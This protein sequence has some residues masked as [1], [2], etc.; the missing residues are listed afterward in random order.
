MKILLAKQP[1]TDLEKYLEVLR[2]RNVDFEEIEQPIKGDVLTSNSAKALWCETFYKEFRERVD[3]VQFFLPLKDWPESRNLLGRMFNRSFSGYLTSCTRM[4]SGYHKTAEHELLHKADNWVRIY[5]GISIERILGISDW[6]DVVVHGDVPGDEFTEYNYDRAWEIIRPYV[7]E[8]LVKRKNLALLGY[9]QQLLILLRT[10]LANLEAK[11]YTVK[12]MIHPFEDYQVTQEYG[13]PNA[14]WYPLT[15]HHIGS[16]YATPIGTPIPALTDGEIVQAGHSK[17]LGYYCY[18]QH[19]KN[20]K[21]YQARFMHLQALPQRKTYKAGE[22]IGYTGDTGF[23]TGPCVHVDV[24]PGE[25]RIDLINGSNWQQM[26]VN[27]EKHF[28]G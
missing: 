7:D 22:T 1:G 11:K 8:A 2:N 19:E 21:T 12:G 27:P 4:R 23:V 20:G 9:F 24:W 28:G 26:T 13:V 15:G 14:N 3:G 17:T 18:F 10:L 16:D 6:D 25:V 5:L